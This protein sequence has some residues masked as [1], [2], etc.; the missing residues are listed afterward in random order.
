VTSLRQELDLK[1]V[2]TP[3]CFTPNFVLYGPCKIYFILGQSKRGSGAHRFFSVPES[4]SDEG[5]QITTSERPGRGV[6]L[7]IYTQNLQGLQLSETNI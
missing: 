6:I 1:R 3:F 5:E 2:H 4:L 7:F